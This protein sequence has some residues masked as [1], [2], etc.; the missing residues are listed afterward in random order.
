MAVLTSCLFQLR[1]IPFSVAQRTDNLS[2][3]MILG[4]ITTMVVILVTALASF[5]DMP[6]VYAW[7]RVGMWA[8]PC[9]DFSVEPLPR[10]NLVAVAGRN[11]RCN[12]EFVSKTSARARNSTAHALQLDSDDISAVAST[13]EKTLESPDWFNLANNDKAPVAVSN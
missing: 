7:K 5:P 12:V 10:L 9:A 1:G 3:Q 4:I 13:F 8:P 11:L 2:V 6:A